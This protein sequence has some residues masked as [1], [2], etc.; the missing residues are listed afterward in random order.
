MAKRYQALPIVID[1][2]QQAEL[3]EPS[4]LMVQDGATRARWFGARQAWY[5]ER[6]RQKRACGVVSASLAM[7][8]AAHK[9]MHVSLYQPYQE[10][11]RVTGKVPA[12]YRFERVS[13]LGHMI[14]VYN[15]ITPA[16]WGVLPANLQEGVAA[17][18]R[19]RGIGISTDSFTVAAYMKRSRKHFKR[20]VRFL[21]DALRDDMP[22]S[23]V[24]YGRG[25]ITAVAH[26]HWVTIVGVY[27]NTDQ[28]QAVVRVSDHGKE[29]DFSLDE[30]FYTARMGGAFVRYNLDSLLH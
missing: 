22:V 27:A 9:P 12:D 16:P 23:M 20:L 6:Y 4:W 28:T 2:A 19:A 24:L 14:D 1:S 3:R 13:Y 30:W 11:G 26:L 17:F 15:Y 25:Q 7:A 5:R 8:Y 18:G 29:K 21:L 10:A